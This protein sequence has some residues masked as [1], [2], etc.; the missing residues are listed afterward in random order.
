MPGGGWRTDRLVNSMR[1]LLIDPHDTAD[2]GAWAGQRWDRI[3]DLGMGGKNT[4]ARWTSQFQCPVTTLDSLRNG[5]DTF[6]RVRELLGAGCGR[7]IDQHGLDWWEIMSLPLHGEL[8]ALILLQRWV[9]TVGSGDEVW[10]SRPGLHASLY[11]LSSSQCESFPFT[12]GSSKRRAGALRPRLQPTLHIATDR[13][14]L[15]QIRFRIPVPGTA[16]KKTLA[17]RAACGRASHRVH[18]CLAN[19]HRVCER[20]SR[21]KLFRSIC[22]SIR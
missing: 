19:W 14:F 8:E 13:C 15:G 10:V 2:A 11:A 16:D 17:L 9:Q 21:G 5:F 3:V 7:L 1:V 22:N 18:Q 20:L 4:Y 6:R 12:A